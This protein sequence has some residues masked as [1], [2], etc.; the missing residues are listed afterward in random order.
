[1]ASTP[2]SIISISD[3][4]VTRFASD[5]AGKKYYFQIRT[6]YPGMEVLQ[7]GSDP[8]FTSFTPP[9]DC[10]K[11]QSHGEDVP[12]VMGS[13]FAISWTEDYYL[14]FSN[15]LDMELKHIRGHTVHMINK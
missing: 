3:S 8:E 10:F 2:Q 5:V 4:S 9:P 12:A 14:Y 7:F 1:M 6:L 15:K 11:L 13:G